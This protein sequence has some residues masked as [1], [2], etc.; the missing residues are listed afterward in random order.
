MKNQQKFFLT[1]LLFFKNK[2]TEKRYHDKIQPFRRSQIASIT[3]LTGILYLIYSQL[4]QLILSQEIL[5][6]TRIIHLYINAPLLFFICLL[7][8]FPKMYTKMTYL[9]MAAPIGA[10]I[11]NLVLV[12]NIEAYTI[13]LTEIYL[14]IFWV[15]TLSGLRLFHACISAFIIASITIIGTYY[16][17]PLPFELFVMHSFWM[18]SVMSFGFLSAYLLERLSKNNFLNNEKLE[19]LALTDNL[20]GL[21]NRTKLDEVLLKELDRCERFNHT[22]GFVML[23]I[24]YFKSVNDTH[25]HQVGDDVLIAMAELI[26]KNIRST[27]ILVRWGGEEFVILC[28]ETNISGVLNLAENI[29]LKIQNHEFE[30]VGFKTVSMGTTLYEKGDTISSIITRADSALYNAKNSGRNRIEVV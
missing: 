3:L 9:L 8:F 13:Y 1:S 26:K 20:T 7:S 22:F 25:G 12:M 24:D 27:D 14:I 11:G 21:Y 29:R 30:K 4:D 17:F 16:I 6:L 19:K 23:D 5:P 18:V 10:T 28:L 15:F 2:E